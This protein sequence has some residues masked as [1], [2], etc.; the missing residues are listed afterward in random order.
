L[1][2]TR[3]NLVC[4][5]RGKRKGKRAGNVTILKSKRLCVK[6]CSGGSVEK[7]R[8]GRVVGCGNS[9]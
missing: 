9:Q 8:K 6:K 4:G 5:R 1:T 3:E 2:E 7:K